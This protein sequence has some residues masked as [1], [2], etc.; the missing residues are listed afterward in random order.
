MADVLVSYGE[1]C[2]ECDAG[3]RLSAAVLPPVEAAV[4]FATMR[5]FCKESDVKT[6]SKSDNLVTAVCN[7]RPAET[8]AG[9]LDGVAVVSLVLAFVLL[10]NDATALA[11]RAR[12]STTEVDELELVCNATDTNPIGEDPDAIQGALFA[13]LRGE[14]FDKC[15]GDFSVAVYGRSDAYG[16]RLKLAHTCR[17]FLHECHA[18]LTHDTDFAPAAATVVVVPR[19]KSI[20]KSP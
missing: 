17:S 9:V 14:P 18:L 15:L 10:E 7:L 19:R 12:G 8:L 11:A 3:R 13:Y 5:D 6:A 2:A 4:L 20:T 1:L 16:P